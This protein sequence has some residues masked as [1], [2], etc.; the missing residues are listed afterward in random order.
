MAKRNTKPYSKFT[1]DD[2]KTLGL[3]T[4]I[5]D[6][7]VDQIIAPVEPSAWLAETLFRA[8]IFH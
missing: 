8:K 2:L 6:L 4:I 1:F 7:F 3:E 5:V